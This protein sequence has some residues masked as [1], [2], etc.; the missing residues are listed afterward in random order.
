MVKLLQIT[1][2]VT[3]SRCIWQGRCHSCGNL[4][5]VGLELLRKSACTLPRRY[6]GLIRGREGTVHL[7]LPSPASC[8]EPGMWGRPRAAG[9]H[10]DRGLST[11][12]V[13]SDRP[14]MHLTTHMW[15]G[16]LLWFF[17]RAKP[18][19]YPGRSR[20]PGAD[21]KGVLPGTTHYP[22]SS[23]PGASTSC[24]SWHF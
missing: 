12:V 20:E 7:P 8:G 4:K 1:H 14:K 15:K 21:Y 17:I 3:P 23:T 9:P 19:M 18:L 13:T 22:A 5:T 24:P 11:T 16:Q 6:R 2:F 10:L